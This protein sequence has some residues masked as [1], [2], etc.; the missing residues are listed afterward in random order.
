MKFLHTAISTYY[1]LTLFLISWIPPPLPPSLGRLWLSLSRKI[2]NRCQIVSLNYCF[3]LFWLFSMRVSCQAVTFFCW[4]AGWGFRIYFP[5]P[6]H[7]A[8]DIAILVKYSP[9]FSFTNGVCRSL[10]S[11]RVVGDVAVRRFS[12]KTKEDQE[13]ISFPSNR[14]STNIHW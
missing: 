3:L 7:A 2:P 12:R 4:V 1:S 9:W 8:R 10:L 11:P 5:L 6:K 14:T 13:E